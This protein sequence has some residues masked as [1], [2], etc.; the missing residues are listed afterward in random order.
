MMFILN[1]NIFIEKFLIYKDY[2]FLKEII[3]RLSSSEIIA[4][5][6]M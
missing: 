1:V 4:F 5:I 3:M 6:Y 2:Y